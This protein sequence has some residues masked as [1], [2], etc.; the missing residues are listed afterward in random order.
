[1][2][3]EKKTQ[4]ITLLLSGKN[5][6][7]VA[8]IVGISRQTL[9]TWLENQEVIDE[10]QKMR[11]ELIQAGNEKL[12]SRLNTYLDELH[13]LAMTSTDK[14]TKATCLMYLTDRILGK[15]STNIEKP[16]VEDNEIDDDILDK[17]INEVNAEEKNNLKVIK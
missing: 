1:M 2:L 8:G 11:D 3:D 7:E 5:K 15:A 12:T 13:N 17:E 16:A 6:S 4:A 10:M 14:R 9:Y